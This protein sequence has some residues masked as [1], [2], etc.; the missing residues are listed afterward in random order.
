MLSLPLR[1]RPDSKTLMTAHERQVSGILADLRGG[2]REV[3]LERLVPLVFMPS[4]A[5]WCR[6]IKRG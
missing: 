2:S 5:A 6:R 4:F 1:T 3:A